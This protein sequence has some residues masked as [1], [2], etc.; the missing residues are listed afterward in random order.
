MASVSGSS[1]PTPPSKRIEPQEFMA[2]EGLAISKSVKNLA[3]T[4]L[5]VPK[6]ADYQSSALSL[7]CDQSSQLT[8]LTQSLSGYSPIDFTPVGLGSYNAVAK[9]ITK[10]Y[11]LT[12]ETASL[13]KNLKGKDASGTF[14][15]LNK[16]FMSA[17]YYAFQICSLLG[18]VKS[19]ILHINPSALAESTKQALKPV[20]NAA[21]GL[22]IA[23][24][25]FRGIASAKAIYKASSYRSQLRN[26]VLVS[27]KLETLSKLMTVTDDEVLKKISKQKLSTENFLKGYYVEKTSTSAKK[28]L[29]AM[30]YTG[31]I[32]IAAFSKS[33]TE[34]QYRTLICEKFKIDPET[35]KGLSAEAFLGLVLYKNEIGIQKQSDFINSIADTPKEA[36]KLRGMITTALK[37]SNLGQA[38][39]GLSPVDTSINRLMESIDATATRKIMKESFVV[40]SCVAMIIA[41]GLSI[42]AG[43]A[44]PAA[45]LGAIA[46]FWMIS[47]A[48]EYGLSL[49][50]FGVVAKE[51]DKE[52]DIAY[53]TTKAKNL[54]E[55]LS[56]SKENLGISVQKNWKVWA[57]VASQVLLVALT[58]AALASPLGLALSGVAITAIV[59]TVAVSIFFNIAVLNQTL[60]KA[61]IKH[62][63][64]CDRYVNQKF[65]ALFG[66]KIAIEDKDEKKLEALLEE[67]Q[68]VR[69]IAKIQNMS[70]EQQ[71]QVLSRSGIKLRD[72]KFIRKSGIGSVPVS[73]AERRG[74]I[75]T[76][77]GRAQLRKFIGAQLE[78]SVKDKT[79]YENLRANYDRLKYE[80]RLSSL[81]GITK[82][83]P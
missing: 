20:G 57:S 74:F 47:N 63:D 35:A 71:A 78:I 54:F 82:K 13:P 27:D 43:P 9:S 15:V 62:A 32:D 67:R 60:R 66:E 53:N 25:A 8:Q 19:A 22:L 30:G 69:F 75:N 56:I 76:A 38:R 4:R 68:K 59:I 40:V 70:L 42:A 17:S 83:T 37:T 61:M 6:S 46:A 50:D 5:G 11:D 58:I 23:F 77:E 55:W 64:F 1:G 18:V 48:I 79:V 28:I 80:T 10:L 33:I 16:F 52:L 45:M 34:P 24:S 7:V 39:L 2:S 81:P 36:E 12:Q 49:R 41:C 14:F 73:E 26:A 72:Y 21:Y 51:N 3:K 31:A 29:D 65:A 44:A